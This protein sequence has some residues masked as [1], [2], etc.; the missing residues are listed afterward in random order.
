VHTY[1]LYGFATLR[2]PAEFE[3]VKVDTYEPLQ[4][5]TGRYDV[6]LLASGAN[7]LERLF[8]GLKAANLRPMNK[9]ELDALNSSDY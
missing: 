5:P 8:P 2:V 3:V 1:D 4:T 7:P 6:S 9:T